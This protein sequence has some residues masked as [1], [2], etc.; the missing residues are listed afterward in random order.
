M[1]YEVFPAP[2]KENTGA[3]YF[4]LYLYRMHISQG[5]YAHVLYDTTSSHIYQYLHTTLVLHGFFAF[6]IIHTG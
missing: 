6:L 1:I 2:P 4:I 5:T 3:M